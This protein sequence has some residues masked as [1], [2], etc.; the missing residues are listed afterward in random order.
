MRLR[1]VRRRG[2]ILHALLVT[3]PLGLAIGSLLQEDG[4]GAAPR[5]HNPTEVARP[6]PSP[7][8]PLPLPPSLAALQFAREPRTASA[9]QATVQ[10]QG[11]ASARYLALRELER[12]APAQAAQEAERVVLAATPRDRA[13]ATNALGALARLGAVGRPG[14]QR[15]ATSAPTEELREVAAVLLGRARAVDRDR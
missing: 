4:P 12:Q 5:A 9:A 7:P 13:L 10:G 1:R 15:C 6:Q 3:V 8:K 11:H 2:P 14:L